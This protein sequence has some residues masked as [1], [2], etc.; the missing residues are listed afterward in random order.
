MWVM[1]THVNFLLCDPIPA[2]SVYCLMAIEEAPSF[3][4]FFVFRKLFFYVCHVFMACDV[5]HV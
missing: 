3:N 1:K 5:C 2:E 4:T